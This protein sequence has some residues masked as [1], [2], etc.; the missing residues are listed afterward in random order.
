MFGFGFSEA[1]TLIIVAVILISPKD[2]PRIVRLVG[3]AY[4]RIIRQVN[5]AK[6]IYSEFE[7]EVKIATDM[8]VNGETSPQVKNSNHRVKGEIK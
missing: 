8:D 2:F 7:E 3:N 6:E 4:G 1:I 5:R